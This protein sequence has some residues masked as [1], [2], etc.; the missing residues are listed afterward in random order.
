[1]EDQHARLAPSYAHRW[2]NCPG[3]AH[4]GR[5]EDDDGNIYAQK[6]SDAHE[7][8]AARLRFVFFRTPI[9][10]DLP[11]IDDE[12]A[13]CVD[14]YIQHVHHVALSMGKNVQVLIE[15]HLEDE[16]APEVWGTGDAVLLNS[17]RLVVID[18][19]TGM[20]V[21]EVEEN[22]QLMIYAGLAKAM[23]KAKP[24]TIENHIVQ[25]R[26][27][28][29]DGPV[30]KHIYSV[31]HLNKFW[32]KVKVISEL[33]MSELGMRMFASGDHCQWCPIAGGCTTRVQQSGILDFSDDELKINPTH[34]HNTP[35]GELL[36]RIEKV[37]VL[38]NAS[39][40]EA[41]KRAMNREDIQGYKLIRLQSKRKW[42][43]TDVVM[44]LLEAAGFDQELYVEEKLLSFTKLEK[45][46]A[47]KEIVAPYIIKPE[48]ALGLVPD[49]DNRSALDPTEEARND[50]REN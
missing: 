35:L 21:V 36:D 38:F 27:F 25:P 33:A 13:E 11:A 2:L 18:L 37:E 9:P 19:K 34:L 50:F 30:R 12:M 24:R 7:V 3:S 23:L 17:T 47:M 31:T 49:S 44:S 16:E 39:R 26:T 14:A 42:S 8:A 22:P 15:Q 4:V 10:K 6:G 41:L 45:V 48:G 1:M 28:H 5:K 20:T 40:A 29:V 46:D 43:D 32:N